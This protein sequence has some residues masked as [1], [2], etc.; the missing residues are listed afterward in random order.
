VAYR[1]NAAAF[2]A[3]LSKGQYCKIIPHPQEA[4]KQLHGYCDYVV[5]GVEGINRGPVWSA[6]I[7]HANAMAVFAEFDER[8]S[9]TRISHSHEV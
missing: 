6:V 3:R 7:C 2:F 5:L 1:A 4:K 8:K 9:R